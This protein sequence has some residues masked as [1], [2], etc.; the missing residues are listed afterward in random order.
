MSNLK[1]HQI[2]ATEYRTPDPLLV[3][4]GFRGISGKGDFT[5]GGIS[6]LR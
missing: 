6:D 2:S 5:L 3:E 4:S 1:F